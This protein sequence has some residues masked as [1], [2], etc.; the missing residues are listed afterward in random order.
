[1]TTN[2]NRE[3]IISLIQSAQQHIQIA[4]SWLTDEIIIE[5][6]K[7]ASSRL[8]IEVL[9]SRDPLNAA[10]RFIQLRE[11][12]DLG[13]S[14]RTSGVRFPGEGFMHAKLVIVDGLT[15]YGGS[16]NF[17]ATANF[18]MENWGEYAKHEFP[19]HKGFWEEW[20]SQSEDYLDSFS[21]PWKL[22]EEVLKHFEEEEQYRKRIIKIFDESYREDFK[23]MKD[24]RAQ[25]IQ[26][27]K[28]KEELRQQSSSL[29]NGVNG[30]SGEGTLTTGPEA[31][32][33]KK[34]RNYGGRFRGDFG[35]RK[36]KN[37]HAVAQRHMR[38][39]QT[40]FPFTACR[41]IDDTLICKGTF[42]P[43][44]CE[45]FDFRIE[46][47]AGGSPQVFITNVDIPNDADCHVYSNGSLCLYYPGDQRWTDRTSIA[48]YTIPWVY[49]WI[50]NYELYK[51]TGTWEADYVPHGKIQRISQ[52]A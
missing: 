48:E 17:T 10:F 29:K 25:I 49:E 27:E 1:M 14:V 33:V 46:H 3:R 28:K 45:A 2:G 30:I 34:H 20:T 7:K 47:R 41:I 31:T 5:E 40:R 32:T 44:G 42:Q 18:S 35:G 26:E 43:E 24:E 52:R 21:N 4:V 50:V 37:S 19:R 51:L 13:V 16:H 22:K 23:R 11:L 38:E 8:T 39:L 36:H 12:I 15:S 9:L 6:L